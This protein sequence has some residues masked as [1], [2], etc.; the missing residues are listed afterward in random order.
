MRD[1]GPKERVYD[2][3]IM[4]LLDKVCEICDREG[5]GFHSITALEDTELGTI[6]AMSVCTK[7]FSPLQWNIR[8]LL[9]ML[10]AGDVDAP[11]RF[12]D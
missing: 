1:R 3:E 6:H 2:A 12:N 7:G 8:N 9:Q 10:E 11:T 4:S 5:I